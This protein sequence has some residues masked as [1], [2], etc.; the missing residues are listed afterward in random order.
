MVGDD[1]LLVDE[2]SEEEPL[3]LSLKDAVIQLE[4]VCDSVDDTLEVTEGDTDELLE[5]ELIAVIE[6]EPHAL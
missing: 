4:D 2:D 3:T 6:E 5:T 1:E